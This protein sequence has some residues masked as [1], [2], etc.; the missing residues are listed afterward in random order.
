MSSQVKVESTLIPK[1]V[2]GES[3]LTQIGVTR[4]QWT[5]KN[6]KDMLHCFQ[7]IK[8]PSFTVD[9]IDPS[10]KAKKV[11][12][13]HLEMEILSNEQIENPI[14]LV[15][16]TGEKS[17]LMKISLESYGPKAGGVRHTG[18]YINVSLET[19]NAFMFS[20]KNKNTVMIITLPG[21]ESSLP[22]EVTI[23]IQVTLS[24]L[25]LTS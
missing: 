11:Q 18:N 24:Q 1:V 2:K 7:T 3:F 15:Q 9:I 10:T 5:I 20:A 4:F 14:H 23:E 12:S 25:Y 16:D 13:Y 17:L 19:A 22:E 21:Y 8:S 6:F